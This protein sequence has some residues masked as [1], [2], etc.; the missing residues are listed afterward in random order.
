MTGIAD[1]F[2]LSPTRLRCPLGFVRNQY[3]P[4]PPIRP[5]APSKFS[6]QVWPST[7]ILHLPAGALRNHECGRVLATNDF[8][9]VVGLSPRHFLAVEKAPGDESVRVALEQAVG[10]LCAHGAWI[11][12]L[13]LRCPT[14]WFEDSFRALNWRKCLI[15][16]A[17]HYL[18]EDPTS[19]PYVPDNVWQVAP[20]SVTADAG[21][22]HWRDIEQICEGIEA[23]DPSLLLELGTVLATMAGRWERYLARQIILGQKN[24]QYD[25]DDREAVALC[26]RQFYQLM[27]RFEP[28]HELL[29]ATIGR[30][31]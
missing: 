16:F 18:A 8:V 27:T 15:Y 1:N 22:C 20:I 31:L 23:A 7:P 9:L 13:G 6:P 4:I 2:F 24:G 28:S 17:R 29:P 30:L 5:N 14:A 3:I 12:R 25:A 10:F 21:R 11:C 19:P 26:D